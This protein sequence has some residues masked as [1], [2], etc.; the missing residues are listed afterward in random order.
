MKFIVRNGWHDDTSIH[1]VLDLQLCRCGSCCITALG[2]LFIPTTFITMS[3]HIVQEL[4][5]IT[6]TPTVVKNVDIKVVINV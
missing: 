6:P 5:I 2:K 3:T 1:T 4:Q